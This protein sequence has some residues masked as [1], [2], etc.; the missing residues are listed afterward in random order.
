MNSD[1][2]DQKKPVFKFKQFGGWFLSQ[3]T[4]WIRIDE[5]GLPLDAKDE[6]AYQRVW[7]RTIKEYEHYR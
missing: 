7:E 6:K 4:G 5:D 3:E 1:N 2:I